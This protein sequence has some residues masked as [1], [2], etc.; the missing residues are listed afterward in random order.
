MVKKY[1][2]SG[3]KGY[4]IKISYAFCNICLQDCAV[5]EGNDF[6]SGDVDFKSLYVICKMMI[7]QWY[8]K[9]R[10]EV[11]LKFIV[12]LLKISSKIRIC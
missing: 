4:K 7:T 11:V 12:C 2:V 6:M 1:S 9:I 5:N 10:Q 3:V 8:Y